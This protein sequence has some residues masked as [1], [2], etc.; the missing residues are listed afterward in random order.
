MRW[1]ECLGGGW[2]HR[3]PLLHFGLGLQ[4]FDPL[5]K[6]L[7]HERGFLALTA[8]RLH[9]LT[10]VLATSYAFLS[11]PYDMIT[12]YW[13]NRKMNGTAYGI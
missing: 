6:H 11:S 12:E 9:S 4:E 5:D 13:P 3:L 1:V 8:I 10:E 7:I 2:F